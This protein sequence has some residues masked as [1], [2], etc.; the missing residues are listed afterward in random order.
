MDINV[1]LHIVINWRTLDQNPYKARNAN[2]G[3]DKVRHVS[4]HTHVLKV[5]IFNVIEKCLFLNA[6]AIKNIIFETKQSESRVNKAKAD[7]A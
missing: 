4:K 7:C 6:D 1:K 3:E 2:L 5:P